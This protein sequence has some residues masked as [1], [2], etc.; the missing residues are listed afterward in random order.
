MACAY[1]GSARRKLLLV[2][3]I[4]GAGVFLAA[5]TRNDDRR[6]PPSVVELRAEQAATSPPALLPVPLVPV[7]PVL[8]DVAKLVGIDF[9][10]FSDSRSNRF[11]LPEVMGGGAA[12]LDY[13]LDGWHDLFVV[14]GCIL[15]EDGRD[16]RHHAHLFRNQGGQR[17]ED[18]SLSAR[19][20]DRG[21][22][23]GAC[24]GDANN[25]GFEDIFVTH[26]GSNRWYLNN[27]DGTF[28]DQTADAGLVSSGWST[29]AAF[30]DLDLDGDL[31]LYVAR[32]VKT[33]IETIPVCEYEDPSGRKQPGY[34]GPDRYDAEPDLVYMNN[35]DAT[36]SEAAKVVGCYQP[37]GK[38]LAV[39]IADLNNDRRPDIYVANDMVEN[40][41]FE[42]RTQRPV[43]G[44]PNARFAEIGLA[45]GTAVSGDGRPG[46]SMGIACGDYNEDGWHDLYVTN[47][48]KMGN[49]LYENRQ[50]Y[51]G[52]ESSSRGLRL[53]SLLVLGFG[54]V[55]LD[56]DND[57][58]LDLFVTNGHVLGPL[59]GPPYKMTG[60]LY[61]N[62]GGGE[63]SELTSSAGPYFYRKYLGRAIAVADFRNSG[64]SGAAIVH[65]DEPLALLQNDTKPTGHYVGFDLVGVSSNRSGLNTQIIVH[66]RTRT[67][68]RES[69]GGGS[70]LSDGDH[71]VPVGLGSESRVDRVEVRWGSG[72]TD[73]WH[74]L[75][76]DRYWLLTEGRPPIQQSLQANESN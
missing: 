1:R 11:F 24:T 54:A 6:Q 38:G 62:E 17:F 27:G 22:G 58:W 76:V 7:R 39:V 30:G 44:D 67:L 71:R 5:L 43:V 59:V 32:Y 51:F 3:L 64:A 35:G 50:G 36:F 40:Y 48:I 45:S 37:G 56:Y 65:Q 41:L 15:P 69:I 66:T 8:P 60:Q 75:E 61:R 52:D 20:D 55:F 26:F 9:S 16:D 25:D 18:V 57:G 53:P 73:V 4:L 72:G 68:M 34:C 46:A 12:W 49:T 74:N 63:F 31:D 70:Y 28:R 19:A 33:T 13:D 42:N 10:Y 47:Y 21:Y 29:S 2:A 23:Q 14:N